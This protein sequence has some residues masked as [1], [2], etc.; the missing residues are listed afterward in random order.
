M[1]ERI[2]QDGNIR[3]GHL[4][5]ELALPECNIAED[6]IFFFVQSRY[7]FMTSSSEPTLTVL[8]LPWFTLSVAATVLIGFSLAKSA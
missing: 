2:S 4:I 1:S 6:I 7:S 3:G 8:L 5:L